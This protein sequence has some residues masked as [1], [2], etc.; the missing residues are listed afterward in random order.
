MS[1]LSRSSTDAIQRFGG[2]RFPTHLEFWTVQ[3]PHVGVNAFLGKGV[4]RLGHGILFLVIGPYGLGIEGPWTIFKEP[5]DP[6]FMILQTP[7]V[8]EQFGAPTS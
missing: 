6:Q 1:I 5:T 4:E 7:T 8:S 3:A 2:S